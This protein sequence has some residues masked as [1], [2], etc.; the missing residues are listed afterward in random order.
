MWRFVND[1]EWTAGEFK[2]LFDRIYSNAE[3]INTLWQ[4]GGATND[5]LRR[6]VDTFPVP[7]DLAKRLLGSDNVEARVVGLKL[8]NRCSV[9]EANIVA[10][11]VRALNRPEE[12]ERYGGLYE[13]GNLIDRC[14]D[15]CVRLAVA[16]VES[17]VAAIGAFANG[18][19]DN[20][21]R[22][23]RDRIMC[24]RSLCG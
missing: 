13:A 24:L 5:Y 1:Y 18:R 20:D 8:Y 3:D 6:G 19:D 2:L 12:Y 11:I 10:E 22:V 17:L 14:R 23:A 15:S 9:P 21:Q 16:D 7:V 4:L